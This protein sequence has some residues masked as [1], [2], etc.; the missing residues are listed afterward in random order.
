LKSP[1]LEA[2]ILN[3][4]AVSYAQLEKLSEAQQA[5]DRS[6]ILTGRD[7]T[8]EEKRVALGAEAEIQYR[9]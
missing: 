2:G 3:N 8:S 4:I 9:R 1:V 5:A 7:E 6:L